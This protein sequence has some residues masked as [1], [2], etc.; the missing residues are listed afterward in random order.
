VDRLWI[1]MVVP[2]LAAHC[3]YAPVFGREKRQRGCSAVT[4]R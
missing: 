1:V 4:G 2:P 3:R